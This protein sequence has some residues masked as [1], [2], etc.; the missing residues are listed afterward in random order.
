[1]FKIRQAQMDV[2]AE[3]SWQAFYE[4][5][6]AHAVKAFP[7]RCRGADRETMMETIRGGRAR[8][9]RHGLSAERDISRYLNLMFLFGDDFDANPAFG[10]ALQILEDASIGS[11]A[12]R[13]E[14][15]YYEAGRRREGGNSP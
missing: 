6:H 4:Q 1:M 11:P 13:F 7:D 5:F 10:W 12:D 8:A 9:E 3:M 15:L 2:L 14:L